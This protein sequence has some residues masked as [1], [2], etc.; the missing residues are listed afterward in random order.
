M[1]NN[2][3]LLIEFQTSVHHGSG[4]G[5]SGIVDRAI[6]RDGKGIPYLSGAALKGR[7]RSAA[8]RILGTETCAL[9][10]AEDCYRGSCKLCSVFGGPMRRG[11]A[12]FDNG[13]PAGASKIVLEAQIGAGQSDVLAGGSEVR[14][15]TAISRERRV[16]Q[17]AH[18]YSTETV[19]PSVVFKSLIRGELTESQDKLLRDCA[20]IL[21]T[22]GGDSSRGLGFCS[23]RLDA[24]KEG[25]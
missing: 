15:S 22:F 2:R 8:I 11:A 21:N 12:I 10:V 19:P 9:K 3:T 16:V 7:F 23:Y 6:L 4:F 1:P 24:P 14:A 5:L 13:Y 18:L 17:K 25:K 20:L